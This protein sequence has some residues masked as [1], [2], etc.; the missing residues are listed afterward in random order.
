M[1]L[2]TCLLSLPGL[3]A[4]ALASGAQAA[5]C[6]E[7]R[8]MTLKDVKIVAAA[9]VSAGPFRAQGLPEPVDLPAFCRVEGVATPTP[10]SEIRFE[11]WIPAEGWSGRFQGV[12]VGGY[13]GAISYDAM[14]VALKRGYAV[15]GTDMGH[16]G[17]DL[18]FAQG[19]PE[20]MIDWGWR[21]Q[22]VTA[23]VG[24]LIVRNQAGRFP[25]FS[26]FVG[27]S[28]GGHQ[29]LSEAQRFPGD[30]DGV[31]VGDPGYDRVR[32]T[33]A[34]LWSWKALHDEAGKPLFNQAKLQFVTRSAV[35]LCD[36]Q[37]GVTDGVINEPRA[38]RFD[39]ASLL[40]KAAETDSCLTAAQV[41]GLKAVY[42]GARN[43]RTGEQIFPGWSIGS[44]G[45]GAGAG[46][47][48][49]AYLVNPAQP[50]RSEVYKYILFHDP[51]WDW[52]TFD[53][54]KDVAYA[55]ATIP[56]L[57]AV[58]TN[59]APFRA[60]GGKLLMYTGW[61][62]PVAAPEDVAKYYEE[63]TAA[64]GGLAKT[65]EFFR[66]F[67][68]PGMGHCGGGPGPNS[69]DALTAL[70]QWVELGKAP[71]TLI[72][73]RPLD[74]GGQRTRPLCLYPLSARWTGRGSTDDAA[75]FTCA[76]PRARGPAR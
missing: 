42:A 56:D 41:A 70:E 15:A 60:R 16:Q 57:A 26:Y 21:A 25:A 76:A 30:Y 52:R 8:A 27:C 46:Q 6:E 5:S 71:E 37:D 65:R 24:K 3:A 66:F 29:G 19:K 31:L 51:N 18:R 10:Q 49:G 11:V 23:E 55:D 13:Q 17:D 68:A 61:A 72:A 4:L 64:N 32:Q 58:E 63:A 36:P 50:M 38:C 22:H 33:A 14:V 45:F 53:F 44:E 47:G 67:M 62:D 35:A 39:P 73:S 69:F 28:S 7:L 9:R 43:P 34:Y 59:L 48:W 75:N 74:G 1:L 2:K 40:C 54:D 20:K 12:G